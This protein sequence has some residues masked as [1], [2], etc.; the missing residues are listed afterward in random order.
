MFS[1]LTNE[2]PSPAFPTYFIL[3]LLL[4]VTMFLYKKSRQYTFQTIQ[5]YLQETKGK[6]LNT[7]L[8]NFKVSTLF[9]Y[10]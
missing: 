10:I 3:S 2:K 1:Q 4:Q 7:K 8:E 6:Y 5:A 9:V